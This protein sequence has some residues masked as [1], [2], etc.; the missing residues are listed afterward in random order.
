M[1]TTDL[2]PR[3]GRL[4]ARAE[5]QDL[6]AR[7]F[8][9]VDARA[10]GDVARLF[11]RAGTIETPSGLGATGTAALADFFEARLQNYELTYHYPHSELISLGDDGTAT[12]IVDAHAE[13]GIDGTCVIA[14][15]RYDDAYVLED[16]A[17]R[18]ARR[19]LS[20][21]YFLP[22]DQLAGAYREGAVLGR[23]TPR[24]G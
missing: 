21:R 2:L 10:Y 16:G 12:G 4:E 17:W 24:A 6:V 11:A 14:A 9:G 15:V 3:L 13:H 5:I 1:D 8:H 18:F 19:S 22:W 23:P 20:F 7:Y